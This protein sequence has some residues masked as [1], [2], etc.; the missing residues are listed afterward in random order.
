VFAHKIGCPNIYT[1]GIGIPGVNIRSGILYGG[2][3]L[4]HQYEWEQEM[5]DKM[6]IDGL[7]K[8]RYS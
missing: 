2:N 6:L 3:G 8:N 5:I 7:I 1:F 4:C